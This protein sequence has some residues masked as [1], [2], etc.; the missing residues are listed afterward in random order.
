M[1]CGVPCL[2]SNCSALPEVAAGAAWLVEPRDVDAI[3]DGLRIL[4]DDE[5]WCEHARRHSLARAAQLGW[6]QCARETLAVYRALA[7]GKI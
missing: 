7:P 3:R 1:A 6:A 5:T 4:L 2:T